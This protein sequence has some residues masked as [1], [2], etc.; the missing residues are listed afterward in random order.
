MPPRRHY[1]ACRHAASGQPFSRLLFQLAFADDIIIITLLPLL[2]RHCQIRH[3]AML[4]GRILPLIIS[5]HDWGCRPPPELLMP[6]TSLFISPKIDDDAIAL[7]YAHYYQ[8][9]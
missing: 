3:Y 8:L 2:S 4:V 5:R 1:Y 6:L 7:V 9:L